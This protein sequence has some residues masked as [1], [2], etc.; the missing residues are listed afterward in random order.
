M[1][2]MD[3]S[4]QISTI[5]TNFLTLLG[6]SQ[7]HLKHKHFNDIVESNDLFDKSA[8]LQDMYHQKVHHTT[9][10]LVTK[11]N[12]LL[13]VNAVFVPMFD[14]KDKMLKEILLIVHDITSH[15]SDNC[16]LQ[17]IAYY[18]QV[19]GVL[20]RV[21]FD[22]K[23]DRFI[24]SQQPFSLMFLDLDFFKRV[25]DTY[26]HYYGDQ[27]LLQVS[28][29]LGLLIDKNSFIAR[30]GGDEFILLIHHSTQATTAQLAQNIVESI[31]KAYPIED[32]IIHI[33]VSIGIAHF[34]QDTHTKEELIEQADKAMYC[35]KNKGRNQFSFYGE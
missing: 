21:G 28:K 25:N 16:Q 17:E 35:S 7:S 12:K 2:F 1:L 11:H 5:N 9:L 23:I 26:G 13:Y 24:Q 22:D 33:G 27:I 6:Y 15:K 8:I 20:N 32:K 30:Y 29:R 3:E 14:E 18:D 19:T 31:S 10:K 4:C 34:P